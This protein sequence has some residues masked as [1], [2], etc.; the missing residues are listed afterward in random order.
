MHA[1][2]KEVEKILDHVISYR[3]PHID[4][5]SPMR[6]IESEL[7]TTHAG[8]LIG[9][10]ALDFCKQDGVTELEESTMANA[11]ERRMNG[12]S[13]FKPI[14]SLNMLI[15]DKMY[16]YYFEKDFLLADEVDAGIIDVKRNIAIIGCVSNFSNFLDLF[17]KTIRNL[18]VGVPCLVLSRSN[19]TQHTFRWTELLTR[20]MVNFDI[21]QGMLTYAS[22]DL[23]D[24]S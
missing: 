7:L 18:E 12:E 1:N 6:L 11:V 23:E 9:N 19:T 10:Q 16:L 24:V 14:P 22:C 5:R 8:F 4:L 13:T 15:S 2:E 20:M 3:S 17:R 21:D